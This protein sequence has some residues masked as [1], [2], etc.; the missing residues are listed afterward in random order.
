MQASRLLSILMLLQARGRL[1][2]R[3]L[4]AELEVSERTI[5]RDI[6]QLSAAGVPLWGERGRYGGFVLASGWTTELTGM[7]SAESQALLLAGLPGPAKELGLGEAAVSSRLKLLASVPTALRAGAAVV[8]ER[9]HV[10]PV[11]WYRSPDPPRFLQEAAQAVWQN[12]RI[13]VD[14]TSWNSR[15]LRTLEPLGLVLKAGVWYLVACAPERPDPRTYRLSS[16]TALQPG[17][18]TF[19]RPTGFNLVD[20]WRTASS[21]FEAGLHRITAQVLASARAISWM[22]QLRT[23]VQ[24][25]TDPPHSL[26]IPAGWHALTL[27]LESMDHGARQL[28]SYGEDIVVIAPTELRAAVLRLAHQH[29]PRLWLPIGGCATIV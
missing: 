14:Y 28:L 17:T 21:R 3:A 16:I 8:A 24:T 4:A 23:P 5:L 15:A 2:A 7:T 11:D 12:L 29:D 26:D 13:E 22:T 25:W 18:H 6:D 10:D 19:T 20:Y 27:P 9:L 1:S